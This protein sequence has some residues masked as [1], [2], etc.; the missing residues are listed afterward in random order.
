MGYGVWREEPGDCGKDMGY[1][2]W[3]EEPGD[4]GKD[5]GLCMVFGGRSLGTV[6]RIWGCLEGGAWGLW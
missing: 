5:M 4:C 3:R 6:V 2:V 1:G